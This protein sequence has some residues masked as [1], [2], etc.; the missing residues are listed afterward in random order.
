MSNPTQR[1]LAMPRQKKLIY[2]TRQ[3]A[4]DTAW[5]I[6]AAPELSGPWRVMAMCA[7][8]N[9]ATKIVAALASLEL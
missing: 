2:R 1:G 8:M 5:L 3:E 7:E 6:E 9:Y 4:D